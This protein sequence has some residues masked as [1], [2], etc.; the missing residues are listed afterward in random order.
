M[1][2][3]QTLIT[4]GVYFVFMLA[5]GIYFYKKTSNVEDYILGGRGLGSWVTALS[6]QASD[7]SGWLLMGLPGAVFLS[8]IKESWIAIGL[9]VGTALNWILVSPRLRVYTEK[10][11]TMTLSSFFEERFRDPTGMFR[12]ISA[13]ITLVFFTIYAS[14]GLV[15]SGKLFES[16]FNIDYTTA[17]IVG[18]VVIVLYTLLGGYLA[19]CWTD[20]F[21]GGLM[22]FAIL[23]VP[24]VAYKS[25]GGIDA[26]SQAIKIKEIST[27]LFTQGNSQVTLLT[28]ISTMAWGLGY[29]GQPHILTRFMG[30]KSVKELPKSIVIALIWV[31][32]SLGGSIVIGLISIPMFNE[33]NIATGEHEKVFIYMISKLFNPWVGGILLA[34]ILSAIM[35]TID[36]QL[37]V[38]SSTLTED[39]YKKIIK[40]DA[41]EK[42]LVFVGRICVFLISIIALFLAL[43]PNKTILGLVAY[44]WGGFGAAFGPVVLYALF[45]RKTTWKSAISGMIAGTIVLI[46]WKNLGLGSVMY[47]IVPGFVVNCIVISVV[48]IFVKQ[49]DKDILR[50]FDQVVEES[51]YGTKELEAKTI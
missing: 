19:V 37:L 5:I 10:T 38:S 29:F 34:A 24:F 15:A 8:G 50:E 28:I 14:S 51:K 18:T 17:V 42:E 43:N 4:F 49:E 21:Q 45:S 46:V 41:S 40:K 35:S 36:S 20:F 44:A 31:L 27:S 11:R 1:I 9:F 48:N 30:I 3:I 13:V 7:M 2:S 23:Y 25:V 22:F 16:M 33:L 32:I 39:F 6:A 47:E 12:V 26:I